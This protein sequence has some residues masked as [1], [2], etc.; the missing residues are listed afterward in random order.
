MKGVQ[1]RVQRDR[2]SSPP[3]PTSMDDLSVLPAHRRWKVGRGNNR[4]DFH[5][6]LALHFH[7]C[8]KPWRGFCDRQ[9]T[10]GGRVADTVRAG[11]GMEKEDSGNSRI[12]VAYSLQIINENGVLGV[13]CMIGQRG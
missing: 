8:T 2:A 4:C 13:V 5:V 11:D 3:P 7:C 6:K 9:A 12:V 1:V 10:D